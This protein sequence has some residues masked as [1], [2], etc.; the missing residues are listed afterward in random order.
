MTR[1]TNQ[2]NIKAWSAYSQELIE[3]FG[4]QGDIARQYL[5]NPALFELLGETA[6]RRIL[7]AGCGTGYLCRLLARQGANVVGL[8]P[9]ES[10]YTYASHREQQERLGITYIQ[11][12]LSLLNDYDSDFDIVVA[13]MVL[14]DIADYRQSMCNC[15]A[16]LRSGGLFVVSLLHPCF[17]EIDSPLFEKGYRSKGYIRVDEYFEEF[18]VKVD[19]GYN[20]HRPL[21]DYL[22]IVIEQHCTIRRIIEPRLSPEGANLIG[23]ND[24]NV[25]VPNFIVVSAMK[26]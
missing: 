14:I 8:E 23:Q 5:L 19:W 24:R 13:N 7:D 18:A 16:S 25:H 12:D 15:I 9:E 4:D 26:L 17:D 20:F 10:L 1:I 3:K 22:N 11:Q 21:S 6:G 2:D